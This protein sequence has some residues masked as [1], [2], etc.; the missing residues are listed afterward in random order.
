MVAPRDI[1]GETG[2]IVSFPPVIR[3]VRAPVRRPALLSRRPSRRF[4]FFSGVRASRW[5][6]SYGSTVRILGPLLPPGET[7]LKEFLLLPRPR[8]PY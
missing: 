2:G 1:T 6:A 3:S 4:L 5:R 8:L 7:P